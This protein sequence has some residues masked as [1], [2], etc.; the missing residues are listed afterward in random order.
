MTATMTLVAFAAGQ[1]QTFEGFGAFQ[2]AETG[3]GS[4]A[5]G[6]K[7]KLIAASARR[8]VCEHPLLSYT[9]MAAVILL[10]S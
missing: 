5:A 9:M 7:T 3:I 1:S 6:Q 2:F 10:S 4:I 8:M